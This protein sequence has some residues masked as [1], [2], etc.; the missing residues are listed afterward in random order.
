MNFT[1]N[2]LPLNKD[3][4]KSYSSTALAFVGDAV[5]ALAVKAYIT[6]SVNAKSGKLHT[7]SNA[8][9]NAVRQSAILDLFLPELSIEEL[10]VVGRGRNA[11]TK[12]KPK[13]AEKGEYQNA[14][15]FEALIGYLYLSGET[16]RLD[17]IINTV[18]TEVKA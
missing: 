9:L 8:Y 18:L 7:L 4:L 15:A 12:N 5:F 3:E 10:G 17:Y 14:T 6:K 2:N 16:A 1:D 13:S 11:Y